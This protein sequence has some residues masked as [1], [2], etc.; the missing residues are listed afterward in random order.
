MNGSRIADTEI[1]F[2]GAQKGDK[3]VIVVRI[4]QVSDA[5]FLVQRRGL[6]EHEGL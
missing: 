6:A 3:S 2:A 4:H 1:L 5:P